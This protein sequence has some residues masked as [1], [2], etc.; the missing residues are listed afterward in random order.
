MGDAIMFFNKY[1][2]DQQIFIYNAIENHYRFQKLFVI[3]FSSL[4][5]PKRMDLTLFCLFQFF[6]NNWSHLCCFYTHLKLFFIFIFFF[7]DKMTEYFRGR[8]GKSLVGTNSSVPIN[9]ID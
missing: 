4:L 9:K 5:T 3:Y 7:L 1:Y 6:S 8:P 2:R